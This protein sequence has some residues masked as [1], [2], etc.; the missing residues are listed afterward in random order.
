MQKKLTIT[1][2][3]RVYAG[4]YRVVS[5]RI[6][7][8]IEDLVRPHVL[9]QDLETAYQQMAQD[10]GHEVEALEWLEATVRDV[11]DESRRGVM[12]EL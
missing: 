10:E 7:R 8:F 5:R 11:G 12:G 4:L 3:A 1:P 2:D 9:D 6:S